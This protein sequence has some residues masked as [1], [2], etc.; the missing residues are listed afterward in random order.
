MQRIKYT[1]S[2]KDFVQYCNEELEGYFKKKN[3]TEYEESRTIARYQEEIELLGTQVARHPEVEAGL[4]VAAFLGKLTKKTKIWIRNQVVQCPF[5]MFLLGLA[6]YN[7][8]EVGFLES[9]Y[10]YGK[11]NVSVFDY[12]VDK[13]FYLKAKE[14]VEGFFRDSGYFIMWVGKKQHN[15]RIP[16]GFVVFSKKAHCRS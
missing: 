13:R 12:H 1:N 3:L 14:E 2:F 7:V 5:L 4:W 9:Y 8:L 6:S 10:L 11:S 15:N 16:N